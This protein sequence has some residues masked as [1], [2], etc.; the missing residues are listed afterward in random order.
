[1]TGDVETIAD[2][3]EITITEQIAEVERELIIRKKIYPRLVTSKVLS[4][5][6]ARRNTERMRAVLRTLRQVQRA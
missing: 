4:P 6:A 5:S 2:P 3:G 1:V